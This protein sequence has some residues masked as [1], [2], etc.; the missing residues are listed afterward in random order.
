MQAVR[1]VTLDARLP[2]S[3]PQVNGSR[4]R[5]T[6]LF[7]AQGKGPF[8]LA[9]GNKAAQ[10][11]AVTLDALIPLALRK[12]IDVEAIPQAQPQTRARRWAATRG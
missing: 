11:A 12:Q 7:N 9:W 2:A 3:L 5:Q 8:M 6:V 10:P 4:D 1:L